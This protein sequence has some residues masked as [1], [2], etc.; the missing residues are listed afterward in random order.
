[1]GTLTADALERVIGERPVDLT[2]YNTAFT[3]PEAGLP[4]NYEKFEFLGDSILGFVAAR[5]LMDRF[6]E[7]QEGYLTIMRT[8]LTRSDQLHRF[9]K[10]LGL[11]QYVVMKGKSVYLGHHRSKRVMEDVFE[12][13]VAAIYLDL[14]L[15]CARQF[16]VSVFDSADWSDLQK[17]RN[18][19]DVLMQHQHKTH[20]DL[21][22]YQSVRNDD[23][24]TFTVVVELDGKKG[25]G[26]DRVKKNAEQKAAKQILI[27]FGIPVDH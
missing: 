18:Y 16:I 19:K 4:W 15:M 17:N 6:P 23:D 22:T 20:A 3:H 11:E 9:A 24:R 7:Q 26:I 5:Y 8:R 2:L 12:A 25:T 14:G 13:L 10:V 1:M 27:A 21:P